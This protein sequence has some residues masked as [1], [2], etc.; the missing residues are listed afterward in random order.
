MNVFIL[1]NGFDLQH[2]FPTKYINFL[3][4]IWFLRN[5]YDESMKTV[6]DVFSDIRLQKKDGWIAKS[7]EQLKWA[8][9]NVRL[10]KETVDKIVSAANNN[11][12]FRYLSSS[13]N[14]DL[15]W[16][17]FEK[18]IARVIDVLSDYF[19]YDKIN[20]DDK[21][22]SSLE[23]RKILLRF[24]FLYE[25]RGEPAGFNGVPYKIKEDYVVES[26]AGSKIYKINKEKIAD[27]F[28]EELQKFA[29]ILKLYLL[30]FVDETVMYIKNRGLK[31]KSDQYRNADVVI[32][33]N[34]T[35]V[36]ENLY[37]CNS[38]SHI[39]GKTTSFIVL[40][41]N[42]DKNDEIESINTDFLWFKKYYQRVFWETD[43][44]FLTIYKELP[45][46]S[47]YENGIDLHISGHS[48]DITDSDIL[49]KMIF[50]ANKVTIYYHDSTAVS[51][52]IKNLVAMYGKEEFDIIREEKD[53]EF[54]MNSSIEWG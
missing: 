2:G 25:K 13:Y 45:R 21:W 1:G 20:F 29:L 30:Y 3:N 19:Y 32:T 31:S 4:V 6:A 49:R 42:P 18:E 53:L 47:K 35:K 43:K 36:F 26:L 5:H 7:Y 54:K 48:L 10:K 50:L 39:H 11:F 51:S 12:W 37:N 34:Y 41:V 33:F 15:G 44:E 23:K 46:K 28:Y 17:D 22:N 38:I 24:P 52:Y 9:K 14:K 27:T 40:G 16:I 8:Y